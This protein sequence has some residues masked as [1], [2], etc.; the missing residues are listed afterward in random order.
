MRARLLAHRMNVSCAAC[1]NMLDP[2]GLGLENFESG[3]GAFR[4]AWGTGKPSTHQG[5][6]R[7]ARCSTDSCSSRASLSTGAPRQ[8][9]ML[10]FAVQQLMTY[11]LA[12]P[13]DLGP[14]GA[15]LPYVTAIQTQWAQQ[16]YSFKT[17]PAGR[18]AQRETFR[19]RHGEVLKREQHEALEINF[20]PLDAQRGCG[21]ALCL[22]WLETLDDR[23]ATAA[24]VPLRR[25]MSMYFPNGTTDNFWLPSNSGAGDAW[26][27]SP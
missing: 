23:P 15:D 8:T 18:R 9:E 16:G 27:V 7:T 12:R 20:P 17:L 10:T 6:C 24:A 11:A 22:P 2:I 26:S 25:Y 21:H 4:S 13:L 3:I 5:C 1:H 19:S 14:T